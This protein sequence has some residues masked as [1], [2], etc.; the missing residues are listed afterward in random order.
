M[1][2]ITCSEQ[3]EST[4]LYQDLRDRGFQVQSA[5]SLTWP[6]T[7]APMVAL[8]DRAFASLLPS[9]SLRSN[10]SPAS[11]LIASE[12]DL[13]AD[14]EVNPGWPYQP[15][16]KAIQVA[17]NHQTL[18]RNMK[19]LA[20]LLSIERE[21]LLQ[22]TEI[23]VALSAE[24]DLN[25]LLTKILTEGRNLACCDAASL[26]LVDRTDEQAP[27]LLF[28][29]TQNDSISFP[30]EE[31]RFPLD[32]N[33]LAGYVVLSGEELNLEDVY[34]APPDMPWKFNSS[35]DLQMG[36]RTRSMLVIPMSNHRHEVIGALQFI[37]RKRSRDV[38]LVDPETTHR[39]TIPFDKKVADLMRALASQAAVAIDNSVLLASIQ[40]LF[41]GFVSAS[42]TAIEQRDPTTSGHS[43]RVAKLTT[44]LAQVLPRSGVQRYRDVSFDDDEIKELRYASLLHDFGKVGV[45]E[46]VLVKPT[47]LPEGRLELV[48]H[49]FELFKERMRRAYRDKAIAHLLDHGTAD[50]DRYQQRFDSE[51][52]AELQRLEAFY[53][54]IVQAN[55]PTILDDGDFAH[56]EQIASLP[57]QSVDGREIELLSKAEFLT[58]SVRKG[59][60][61]P[62]ERKEI[63][64]HVVHTF[65]FLRRIPWTNQLSRIP[66]LAVSHHEKLDGSGYPN[67]IAEPEIP[68][69]SKMMTVADIYDAL[70][71]SD[72]PYKPAIETSRALSILE[73]EAKHGLIDN[74]LVGI[75][76]E[77]EIYRQVDPTYGRI[78]DRDGHYSRHVCDYEYEGGT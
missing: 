46:H 13:D 20:G 73:E 72:R 45:R 10:F 47:K 40:T 17:I 5:K 78:D 4:R 65:E 29:L 44:G 61:T 38:K 57:S 28:K 74:Q 67:G 37:N 8:L 48:W 31:N 35:F 25:K 55:K 6:Q 54:S 9:S 75:F 30:F 27:Q 49:R 76:I 59:S 50:F 11:F 12:S 32:V 53:H 33:S 23:G 24:K 19:S 18:Q 69:G 58:L 70:T 77:A 62:S 71:A 34:Q 41:E 14:L 52:E 16:L 39:E 64:S 63:E 51:L 60:L 22:L 3:F 2:L 1:A 42:V 21:Q 68:L 36:Y 15:T 26:F 7:D 66:E 43:F 56:L